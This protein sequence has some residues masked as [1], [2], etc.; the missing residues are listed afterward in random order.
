MEVRRNAVGELRGL[1]A[2][3]QDDPEFRDLVD[4][5]P[6]VLARFQPIFSP[7][8]VPEVTEDEFKSFLYFENN[9]H[10]TGLQR[11]GVHATTDMDLLREGLAVLLDES[12]P[13]GDRLDRLLP[14]NTSPMVRKFG[15]ATATAILQVAYPE[16][17]GVWNG[18]SE[19]AMRGLGLW[20]EFPW[21]APFGQ[22]YDL[23]NG[24]FLKTA[25]ELGIDLWTLDSLWWMH[26]KEPVAAD[27]TPRPTPEEVAH[28]E[29]IFHLEKYLH[30]FIRDNWT[31]TELG[32]EWDLAEEDGEQV[33][34]KYQTGVVGEIDLLARHRTEPRW[35][36]I[37]LKRNQTSDATVGQ[38]LRYMGWVEAEKAA[39]GESV[40]GLIIAH[41]GDRRLEY[42]LK[43]APRVR[44]QFYKVG[45]RLQDA[46]GSDTTS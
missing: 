44:V 38:I 2:R 27:E 37:E 34:F 13:I 26:L 18:T 46:V 35:L 19:G 17:Y 32:R 10:W 15:R 33:G 23:V 39:E 24:V 29:A 28:G 1:M 9:R 42:A 6:E 41:E 30:E 4:A 3:C 22:R 36:V 14:H 31:S 45:F 5:K 16:K 8:H 43:C 40:E 20:P 12:R 25:E 7:E 11:Q 21:G